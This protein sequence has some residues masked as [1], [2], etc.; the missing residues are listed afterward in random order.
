[1]V[2]VRYCDWSRLVRDVVELQVGEK[3]QTEDLGV[4]KWLKYGC[5]C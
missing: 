4:V 3:E 2:C 5:A 1:M